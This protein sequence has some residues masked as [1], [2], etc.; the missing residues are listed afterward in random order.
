MKR[1]LILILMLSLGLALGCSKKA[2]DSAGGA[3]S[4]AGGAGGAGG[5]G[6]FGAGGLNDAQRA[7]QNLPESARA[8]MAEK[9]YFAYDSSELTAESKAILT[10]KAE[11]MRSSPALKVLLEGHCDER[12]TQ[13]YNL[14]LGDRR[15]RIAYNFLTNLGVKASSLETISYGKERP[16]VVGTGEAAWSKNRRV[17][18]KAVW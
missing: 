1:A 13:E 8:V 17:E 16:D 15:A 11:V 2:I 5:D 12:G 18:F 4:G 7:A 14:A 10:R 9:I 3:G 6:G